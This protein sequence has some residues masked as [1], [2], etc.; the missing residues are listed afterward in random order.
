[1]I[2]ALLTV[3][4]ARSSVDNPT[5]PT[6]GSSI[7]LS[8]SFTPPFSKFSDIDYETATPEEKY[9]WVEYTKYMFDV[10]HYLKLIGKLVLETS[11]HFGF[12]N[13]YSPETVEVGPFERYQV[14]GDGLAGQNFILGTDI[15]GL[16]G[17]EK[18]FGGRRHQTPGPVDP[19]SRR[20]GR[21]GGGP[22]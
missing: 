15:I 11:A 4:I 18:S 6:S 13:T 16:R 7:S 20:N 3:Q 1:M 10:K 14:G 21:R 17:Y 22:D 12:M 5:Y 8:G 2:P 9:R 19:G